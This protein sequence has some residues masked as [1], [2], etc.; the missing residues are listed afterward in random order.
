[1]RRENMGV[2]IKRT[3]FNSCE[4]D[5]QSYFDIGCIDHAVCVVAGGSD[6]RC[7]VSPLQPASGS[8]SSFIE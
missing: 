3:D 2:N 5:V 4:T 8:S 7:A 6:Q 1:M